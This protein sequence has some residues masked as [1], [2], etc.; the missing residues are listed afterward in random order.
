[1]LNFLWGD[2]NEREVP[3]EQAAG[4]PAAI[5]CQTGRT[6]IVADRPLERAVIG[7]DPT[8]RCHSPHAV[9]RAICPGNC[10][11]PDPTRAPP[12]HGVISSTRWVILGSGFGILFGEASR[13]PKC[14]LACGCLAPL[15]GIL[16]I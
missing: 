3:T 7:Y 16:P 4:S 14:S 8:P 2:P 13:S 11:A 9:P 5:G 6:G 12:V 15:T 1:M 10:V